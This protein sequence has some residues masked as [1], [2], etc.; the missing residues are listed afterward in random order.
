MSAT[1]HYCICGCSMPSRARGGFHCLVVW[2][3]TNY[4]Y[5]ITTI[6]LLYIILYYYSTVTVITIITTTLLYAGRRDYY[7]SLAAPKAPTSESETELGCLTF[8][9]RI[10]LET[11]NLL[12]EILRTKSILDVVEQDLPQREALA[13]RTTFRLAIEVAQT[14]SRIFRPTSFGPRPTSFGPRP[15]SFGPRRHAPVFS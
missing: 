8:Q 6:L 2:E 1:I 10:I 7:Y 5:S 14:S 9:I 15:T 13:S 3:P 4:H 12:F 11:Y